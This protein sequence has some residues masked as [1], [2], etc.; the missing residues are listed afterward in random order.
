MDKNVFGLSLD[1]TKRQSIF[2]ALIVLFAPFIIKVLRVIVTDE[3]FQASS[4]LMMFLTSGVVAVI[5]QKIITMKLRKSK[6]IIECGGVKRIGAGYCKEMSFADLEII[7]VGR[8]KHGRIKRIRLD[9]SDTNLIISGF[10]DMDRIY[11]I[12]TEALE[13][14]AWPKQIE[15]QGGGYFRSRKT[16]KN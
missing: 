5:T 2:A 1:S 4:L 6:L 12:I 3:K 15:E 8:D 14:M 7:F 10:Q 16:K 11:S 13:K 9:G